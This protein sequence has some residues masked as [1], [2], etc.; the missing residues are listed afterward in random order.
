MTAT[1]E[2]N[3]MRNAQAGNLTWHQ[4]L[5][6]QDELWIKILGDHGGGTFKMTFQAIL[7][8]KVIQDHSMRRQAYHGAA[9]VGNHVEIM[10]K[11]K[12][13][14]ALTNR[15]TWQG[16]RVEGVPIKALSRKGD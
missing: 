5:I 15:C 13:I 11:E 2:D 14:K 9:F 8:E 4:G 12:S 3:I 10:L 6:P 1:V 7:L 16:D